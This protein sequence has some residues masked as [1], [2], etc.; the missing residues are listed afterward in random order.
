[1]KCGNIFMACQLIK[2]SSFLRDLTENVPQL[3]D[4]TFA[5]LKEGPMDFIEHTNV[6]LLKKSLFAERVCQQLQPQSSMPPRLYFLKI[7]PVSKA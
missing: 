2:V 7:D 3:K 4:K 5:K 6:L 1:M